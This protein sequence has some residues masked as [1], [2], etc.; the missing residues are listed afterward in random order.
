ML[1]FLIENTNVFFFNQVFQQSVRIPKSTDCARLLADL[2]L[3]SFEGECIQ[4]I[5]T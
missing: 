2:F 5:G 4:K 1:E 3:Y